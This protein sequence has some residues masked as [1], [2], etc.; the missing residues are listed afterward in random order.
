MEPR[1]LV[2]PQYDPDAAGTHVAAVAAGEAAYLVGSR[3][4]RLGDV[5]GGALPVLARLARRV[6]AY[7]LRY[8]DADVAAEEVLRLWS[9]V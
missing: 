5:T 6:P 7:Q 2:F 8:A 1:L 4:S 9:T 3:S